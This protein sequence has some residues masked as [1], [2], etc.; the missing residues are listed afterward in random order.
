MDCPGG[1]PL[2]DTVLAEHHDLD[3]IVVREHRENRIPATGI[4]DRGGL[5]G[6][7]FHHGFGFRPRAIVDGDLMAGFEQIRRHACAHVAE[8]DETD[9]HYPGPSNASDS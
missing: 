7:S 1:G 4:R 5:L 2:E 6:P 8:P 9:L 3:G